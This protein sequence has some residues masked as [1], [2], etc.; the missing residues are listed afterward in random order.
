M[1]R[2]IGRAQVHKG[3]VR[4]FFKHHIRYAGP[5]WRTAISACNVRLLKDQCLENAKH[6]GLHE[7]AKSTASIFLERIARSC[8]YSAG[9]ACFIDPVSFDLCLGNAE[10]GSLGSNL[11]LSIVAACQIG[12]NRQFCNAEQGVLVMAVSDEVYR[13]DQ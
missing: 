12:V 3:R 13:L 7:T 4:D 10:K 1:D 9:L 2:S 5:H 11:G 6:A 8:G